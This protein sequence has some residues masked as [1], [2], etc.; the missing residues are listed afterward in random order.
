MG[1]FVPE[2]ISNNQIN[3]NAYS[4]LD[5]AGDL[6]I[7]IIN[8]DT[9]ANAVINLDAGNSFYTAAE[10]TRLTSVSLGDTIH[11][12]I[13]GQ[14][15]N[16]NGTCPAYGWQPSAVSNHKTQIDLPAGSAAVVRFRIP[17][18]SGISA[19]DPVC[20]YTLYPN[21]SEGLFFLRSGLVFP[22]NAQAQLFDL[23][24]RLLMSWPLLGR[25]NTFDLSGTSKGMYLLK[26]SVQKDVLFQ[27]RLFSLLLS[28]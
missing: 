20:P 27:T 21:P 24:G 3:L 15:V 16:A 19:P 1:K 11:Q 14:V 4:I 2:T 26:V 18:A 13:G 7:T 28:M 25:L 6:Y 17:G 5:S 10:I 22:E 23:S 8:K 12:T 9:L